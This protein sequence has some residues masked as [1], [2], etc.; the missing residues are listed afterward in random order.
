MLL[1]IP[2]ICKFTSYVYSNINN[3]HAVRCL[4]ERKFDGVNECFSQHCVLI[5]FVQFPTTEISFSSVHFS[6]ACTVPVFSLLLTF[7][8]HYTVWMAK[9]RKICT[10][11]NWMHSIWIGVVQNRN[12]NYY[13]HDSLR[14][15]FFRTW[16]SIMSCCML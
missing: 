3:T 16:Y 12:I 1:N 9:F 14:V 2:L 7:A 13:V 5:I 10:E 15:R 8:L 6:F 11:T 4:N